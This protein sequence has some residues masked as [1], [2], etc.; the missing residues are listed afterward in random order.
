M[1]YHHLI[2]LD[3]GCQQT[4]TGGY[5]LLCVPSAADHEYDGC[6]IEAGKYV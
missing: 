6:I 5:V 2:V 3:Q 1:D 4:V